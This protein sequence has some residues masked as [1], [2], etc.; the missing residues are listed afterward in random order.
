MKRVPD[1]R[2][3]LIAV[4]GCLIEFPPEGTFRGV[5]PGTP[6]HTIWSGEDPA[7]E[8]DAVPARL[9][10]EPW[11]DE[12]EDTFWLEAADF[13]PHIEIGA[14]VDEKIPALDGRTGESIRQSV[15]QHGMDA[16]GW[17]V[18]F[19][20]TGV[21]WGVYVSATGIA[22]LTR[23]AFS[24]LQIPFDVKTH[25]AF[26]AI[27]NHE[28]FHFA[29]DYAIAQ[30]E[31]ALEEPWWRPTRQAVSLQA[32]SYIVAE[33]KLANAYMLRAFR[34]T[35]PTLRV[36]GKQKA[37]RDF[38]RLQ[39]DGYREGWTIR[40][41]AWNQQLERLANEY[42]KNSRH[43]RSHPILWSGRSGYDWASGFPIRPR[44]DW[45][46]C[47]IHLV[48]D[49][50]RLGLPPGWVQILS[51]LSTIVESQS[52]TSR[53]A[54]MNQKIQM[55][56]QRTKA[57]LQQHITPGADFKKWPRGGPDV[58]SVR[59]NDGVRAHLRGSPSK[60]TWTAI[61]IGTHKEM[62]HG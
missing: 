27:L 18:S 19:H 35:K 46:Y 28:L 15:L 14:D 26:H 43:G 1:I 54:R 29:T 30:M 20:V 33:E 2:R 6:T 56:W 51:H 52:F 53:L 32:P 3:G 11:D 10:D 61:D 23:M 21:Q 36:R 50:H 58:Y 7:A 48:H 47:P 49:S 57:R 40:R 24:Q 16:L 45:R 38:S 42:G 37:L 62:G 34:T 59:V 55:G 5:E 12:G 25:L 41:D 13:E 39:P 60:N 31:L 44:I 9:L 17:Y 4:D 22:A 8:A